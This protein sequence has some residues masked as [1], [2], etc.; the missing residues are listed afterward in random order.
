MRSALVAEW[1][2]SQVL[3]PDRSA[4][5]VGDWL[6]DATNRGHLWFW[7]CVLRTL[8]SRIWADFA[9]TP[10]FMVTLALR[11]LLYEFWLMVGTFFLIVIGVSII[12]VPVALLGSFRNQ[13]HWHPLPPAL[14]ALMAQV[15]IGWCQFQA[16]RWIARRAPGKELA[17]GIS[18]CATPLI[19]SFLLQLIVMHFWSPEINRFMASH[20]GNSG[21]VPATL[22][23]E[24]F[25]L[26]GIFWSRHKS[27]RS[28]VQ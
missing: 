17:A 10:G 25:L 23:S 21:S 8:L 3:P 7:S 12:L 2:L 19:V 26:A 11:G 15:W 18:A 22:P 5:T 6:E 14:S 20:P 4:S 13:I 1:I 24:L 27:L 28:I 9:E 16:G